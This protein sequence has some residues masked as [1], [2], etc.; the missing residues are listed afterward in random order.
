MKDKVKKRNIGIEEKV[1]LIT[2]TI[3]SFMLAIYFFG[4]GNIVCM[5]I[6]VYFFFNL[7]C[8]FALMSK[9]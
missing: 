1:V 7:F 4:I 9:Y 2:N 6:G 5:I 3:G 8:F